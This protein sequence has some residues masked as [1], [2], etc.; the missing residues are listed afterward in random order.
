[1]SLPRQLKLTA[2]RDIITKMGLFEQIRSHNTSEEGFQFVSSDGKPFATF[3]ASANG[4][5]AELEI[6]R[7]D[8][9]QILYDATKKRTQYIFGDSIK[10]IDDEEN[11]DVS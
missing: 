8:F 5:T 7:G 2:Q 1:M 6:L 10:R 4:P 3:K 9:A 11:G